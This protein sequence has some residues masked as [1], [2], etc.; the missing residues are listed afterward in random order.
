VVPALVLIHLPVVA[1]S[2]QIQ[3]LDVLSILT[4]AVVVTCVNKTIGKRD[5][6]RSSSLLTASLSF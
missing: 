5:R 1:D 4:K 3:I 2:N 6:Q